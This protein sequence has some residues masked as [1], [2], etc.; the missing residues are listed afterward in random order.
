MLDWYWHNGSLD[1]CIVIAD[2]AL[3]IAALVI[4]C[5]AFVRA[6]GDHV[7]YA[8]R[9]RQL[10][11]KTLEAQRMIQRRGLLAHEIAHEIKNPITAILC[12]AEALDLL[13]G[14][15]IHAEHRQTLRYIRD[16]GDN[17]LRL[18]SDFL[19]VSRAESGNLKASPTPTSV[20]EALESVVGLL[21]SHAHQK[22]ITIQVDVLADQ[23]EALVDPRHLKQVLFNILHNA[24]KFSPNESQIRITVQSQF[25]D[26]R[27]SVSVQDNGP[28]IEETRINAIFD[29]YVQLEQHHKVSGPSGQGLGLGL[30]L[31][32][33]LIELAGG[34]IAVRSTVGVGSSFDI[35][36]PAASTETTLPLQSQS[37]THSFARPH[38]QQRNYLSGKHFLLVDEDLGARE[39]VARLLT[40]W[41]ATVDKVAFAADVLDCIHRQPYDAIL[42]D[43]CE[44]G[45]Y[46][47]ELARLV[48]DETPSAQAKIV[49]LTRRQ[50]DDAMAQISGADLFLEKPINGASLLHALGELALDRQTPAT[51][52]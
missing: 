42:I 30:A 51:T 27:V 34:E 20:T 37:L 21:R 8:R 35:T 44:D 45:V 17:L 38:Q 46:G 29:P 18:V 43:D 14:P 15:N 26:P 13:V 12:S 31:C 41:G 2:S 25:P 50:V 1:E 5:L 6:T 19:D 3:S 47:Y 4:A 48:R 10:Q 28:G 11:R 16:Y 39:A 36:L 40:A 23:V 22:R 9:I 24:L 7:L 33:K 49:L 32:K 52:H